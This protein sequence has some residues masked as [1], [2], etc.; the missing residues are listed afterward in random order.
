MLANYAPFMARP[1]GIFG[2][3]RPG[4][5]EFWDQVGPT[6]SQMA[7]ISNTVQRRDFGKGFKVDLESISMPTGKNYGIFIS[8]FLR[9]ISGFGFFLGWHFSPKARS[10]S[11]KNRSWF[12]IGKHLMFL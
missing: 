7:E 8:E 5:E 11:A 2:P 3:S 6:R 9:K 12:E 10:A 1:R 4:P